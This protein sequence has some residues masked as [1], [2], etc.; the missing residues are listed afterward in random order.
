MHASNCSRGISV[1]SPLEPRM[2]SVPTEHCRQI[3]LISQL[4]RTLLLHHGVRSLNSLWLVP[5]V[6]FCVLSLVCGLLRSLDHVPNTRC[7]EVEC[8]YTFSY[9]L[10]SWAWPV[11]ATQ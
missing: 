10:L 3:I 6:L 1:V 5:A 9:L 11:G 4:M 8:S 7:N 2:N